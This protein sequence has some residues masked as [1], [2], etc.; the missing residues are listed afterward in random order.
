[1][2]T[3][4]ALK[5]LVI[6]IGMVL[7]GSALANNSDLEQIEAAI[8]SSDSAMIQQT[9]NRVR[10]EA[11]NGLSSQDAL[12]S[13]TAIY[14]SHNRSLLRE[15]FYHLDQMAP[16]A[17]YEESLYLQKLRSLKTNKQRYER[18]EITEKKFNAEVNRISSVSNADKDE[19]QDMLQG[20]MFRLQTICSNLEQNQHSISENQDAAGENMLTA[21]RTQKITQLKND[22]T[23][24][25]FITPTSRGQ[26][27]RTIMAEVA[28][29]EASQVTSCLENAFN[30]FEPKQKG[31]VVEQSLLSDLLSQ[32]Q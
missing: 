9:A 30:Q 11:N 5:S 18:G 31:P 13:G 21:D 19:V 10:A 3:T 29:G 20:K 1:M 27:M 17:G 32:F 24:Q 25:D 22:R 15:A 6:S 8:K 12:R 28:P 14:L 7:S 26:Q 2:K 23:W 16:Y 4:P